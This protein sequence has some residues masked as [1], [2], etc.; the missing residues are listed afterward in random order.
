MPLSSKTNVTT[1]SYEGFNFSFFKKF[2]Q[3][4]CSL[5]TSFKLIWTRI[6]FDLFLKQRHFVTSQ[7]YLCFGT[8]LMRHFTIVRRIR[9][10]PGRL[11]DRLSE[12]VYILTWATGQ[13]LRP[14]MLAHL[15]KIPLRPVIL[16]HS[17]K[18]L[19]RPVVL[20]HCTKFPLGPV[21]LHI[22]RR[23]HR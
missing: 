16:A 23:L 3:Q 18:V 1:S 13:Q 6:S 20:A 21:A 2:A 11:E 4:F 5:M 14:V 22:A 19:L 7:N 15:A 10:M 9:R 12:A 8:A 17:T